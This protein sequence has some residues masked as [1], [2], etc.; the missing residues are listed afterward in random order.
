MKKDWKK[1]HEKKEEDKA[2]LQSQLRA[3]TN[4]DNNC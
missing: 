1:K 2:Y 4:K 3:P